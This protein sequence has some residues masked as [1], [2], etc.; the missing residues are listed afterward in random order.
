MK[1]T[2]RK[3]LNVVCTPSFTSLVNW[4]GVHGKRAMQYTLVMRA[5]VGK[6]TAIKMN[7]P[8][9]CHNVRGKPSHRE[10]GINSGGLCE[11]VTNGI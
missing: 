6:Y 1:E 10:G 8:F 5:V 2:V 3:I 11:M 4:R 9:R 7:I